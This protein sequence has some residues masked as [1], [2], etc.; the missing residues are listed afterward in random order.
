MYYT[1][2]HNEHIYIYI[3]NYMYNMHYAIMHT[4]QTEQVYMTSISPYSTECT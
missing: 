1:Y 4:M 3:Y 2:K